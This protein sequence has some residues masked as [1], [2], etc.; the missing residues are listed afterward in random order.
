MAGA[1]L[2]TAAPAAF[3][4]ANPGG[5]YA[6]FNSDPKLTALI[7]SGSGYVPIRKAS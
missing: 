5:K 4:A 3:N 2:I 1:N 7:A 6:L